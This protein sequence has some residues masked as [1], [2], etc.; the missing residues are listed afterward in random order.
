MHTHLINAIS[1][2]DWS[3]TH[4]ENQIE[5]NVECQMNVRK[6][7]N[8]HEEFEAMRTEETTQMFISQRSCVMNP[9]NNKQ[10]L[11]RTD[12]QTNRQEKHSTQKLNIASTQYTLSRSE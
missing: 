4:H 2:K 6:T 7:K 9:T 3:A 1:Q 11:Q 8:Q 12:Q 10:Q 5:P